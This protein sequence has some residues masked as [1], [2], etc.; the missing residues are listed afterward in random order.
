MK[1]SF[2]TLACPKWSWEKILDEARNFGYDGIEIRG[3]EGV[4]DFSQMEPFSLKNITKTMEQLR[5][6]DLEISCLD[7][8][9]KFHE[10]ALFEMSIKEGKEAID[11]AMKLNCKFI[12]VFGNKIPD[13][14]YESETINRIAAGLNQ[15]GDYAKG[16]GVAVLVETHCD[17]S[18]GDSMLKLLEHVTSK[19]VGVLWDL[20]N[21]YIDFGEPIAETF[22]KLSSYI[23]HVHLKDAKG[24]YPNA[25]L[26]LFGQGELFSQETISLLKSAGYEGWLSLEFEKLWHPE[27]EEP[28]I[29]LKVFMEQIKKALK[30][31]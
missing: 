26:C 1:V 11:L 30:T 7:T 18:T 22:N 17:F 16:K 13:K 6:N 19:D 14:S 3:I 15:L 31:H 2:S 8:S 20:S 4:L 25:A 27:L 24:K 21:A 12:R 29:S 9:I 10:E 23:R 28:E 5:R